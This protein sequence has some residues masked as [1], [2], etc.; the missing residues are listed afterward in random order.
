MN[1]INFVL[2]RLSI[3]GN[4]DTFLGVGG[5]KLRIKTI[6]AKLK[7]KLGLSFAIS[8]DFFFFLKAKKVPVNED[9]AQSKVK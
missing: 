9:Y 2:L 4:F 3:F 7:L 1:M 6:S 5:G 8:T